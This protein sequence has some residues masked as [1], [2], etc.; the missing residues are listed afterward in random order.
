M[1]AHRLGWRSQSAGCLNNHLS[2]GFVYKHAEEPQRCD[3]HEGVVVNWIIKGSGNFRSEGKQHPI[4]ENTVCLRRP[5]HDYQMELDARVQH[6][7]CFL[8][9]PQ[10]VYPLLCDIYPGFAELPPV[11]SFPYREELVNRFWDFVDRVRETPDIHAHLLLP[12]ALDLLIELTSEH[13]P[14]P[15]GDPMLEACRLL[16][17]PGGDAKSLP[18]VAE[19]LGLSYHAFRKHFTAR[20]GISPGQYRLQKR[21]EQA[22][23]ALA[24]GDS[25]A[26]VSKNLGFSDVYAFSKQFR[27]MTGS[28][29]GQYRTSQLV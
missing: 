16:S 27:A 18:E 25:I 28:T 29:P 15:P 23:Q 1:L 11:R 20:F 10:S 3:R 2:C 13:E 8:T 9:L 4:H 5:G 24:W 26:D 12:E 22:R 7:R 21:M 14:F 19:Q 6:A 17:E